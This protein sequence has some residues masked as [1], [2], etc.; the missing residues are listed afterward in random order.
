MPDMMVTTIV[1]SV[2]DERVE[3]RRARLSRQQARRRTRQQ[4]TLKF[5]ESD[6]KQIASMRQGIS[7]CA[8]G[9]E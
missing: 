9:I 3:D 2:S 6:S 8:D 4:G 7:E 1:I 5:V